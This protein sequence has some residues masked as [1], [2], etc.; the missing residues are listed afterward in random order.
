MNQGNKTFVASPDSQ[1]LKIQLQSKINALYSLLSLNDNLLCF[2]GR[3]K[4][5][6]SVLSPAN[7]P[8][9]QFVQKQLDEGGRI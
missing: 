6:G 3:P 5:S 2:K 7:R 8:G 9:N 4:D 1:R